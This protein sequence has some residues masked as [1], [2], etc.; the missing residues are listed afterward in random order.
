MLQKLEHRGNV[1]GEC[2]LETESVRDDDTLLRSPD[3]LSDREGVV[4]RITYGLRLG[5]FFDLF[6]VR[7]VDFHLAENQV[8]PWL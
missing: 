1:R 7:E 3:R 2:T 4:D 6:N 5:S 8:R